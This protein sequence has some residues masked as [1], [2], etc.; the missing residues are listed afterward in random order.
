MKKPIVDFP[1]YYAHTNGTISNGMFILRQRKS[2]AGYARVGLRLNGKTKEM[3]VH[4]LVAQCFI[5]N[6]KN[7]PI[8]NH[9]DTN[10][11]NNAVE[12]LEWCTYKENSAHYY[13]NRT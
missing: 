3:L 2:N 7:K 9:L 12:N 8:V 10:K 1:G 4:R 13:K 11:Q 5:E 6:P